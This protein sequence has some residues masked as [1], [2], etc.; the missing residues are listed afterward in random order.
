MQGWKTDDH[1][2]LPQS[3]VASTSRFAFGKIIFLSWSPWQTINHAP[4]RL[5]P[6]FSMLI[7]H[8]HV[9]VDCH[10]FALFCLDNSHASTHDVHRI[11]YSQ[12]EGYL[13]RLGLSSDSPIAGKNV[14]GAK[15]RV[16]LPITITYSV[17]LSWYSHGFYHF[18]STV[19]LSSIHYRV[20]GN[21]FFC[22]VPTETIDGRVKKIRSPTCGM[23]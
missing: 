18:W 11:L 1:H 12:S 22:F 17:A 14:L 3:R 6:L 15:R 2:F 23:V 16:V 21:Q 13:L 4:R 10:F 8:S 9:L 5:S 19:R 7:M 20:S